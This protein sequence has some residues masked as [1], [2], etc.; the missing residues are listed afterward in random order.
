MVSFVF[1]GDGT[2]S[3]QT[4]NFY[5]FKLEKEKLFVLIGERDTL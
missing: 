1:T 3:F 2:G 4:L 5:L